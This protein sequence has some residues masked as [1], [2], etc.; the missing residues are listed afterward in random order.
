[1]KIVPFD[2]QGRCFTIEAAGIGGGTGDD[3]YDAIDYLQDWLEA[4]TSTQIAVIHTVL[5]ATQ[6]ESTSFDFVELDEIRAAEFAAMCH[7]NQ[8]REAPPVNA[9]VSLRAI[10]SEQR[11]SG[12]A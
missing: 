4:Q 9:R 5:A 1:M 10:N 7:A 6:D 2:V 11:R 12:A 8:S 3:P